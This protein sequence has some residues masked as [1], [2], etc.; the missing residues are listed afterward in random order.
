MQLT[1]CACCQCFQSVQ[2]SGG[3]HRTFRPTGSAQQQTYTSANLESCLITQQQA[4]ACNILHIPCNAFADRIVSL[5]A[6]GCKAVG[7]AHLF[8]SASRKA[9]SVSSCFSM[10]FFRRSKDA[11]SVKGGRDAS[12]KRFARAWVSISTSR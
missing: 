3:V 5:H 9:S 12:S 1:R 8:S 6:P 7:W 2:S 4:G 10:S 11:S